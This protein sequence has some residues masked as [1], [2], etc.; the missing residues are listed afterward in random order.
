MFSKL[1]K[2][3]SEAGRRKTENDLTSDQ[4]LESIFYFK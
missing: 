4:Y 3:K 2:E 1:V